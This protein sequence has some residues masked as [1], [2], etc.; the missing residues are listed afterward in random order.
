MVIVSHSDSNSVVQSLPSAWVGTGASAPPKQGPQAGPVS[1]ASP[2]AA[3][4]ARARVP[5]RSE[6]LRFRV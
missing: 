1:S 4:G 6:S 3:V 2:A 5:G